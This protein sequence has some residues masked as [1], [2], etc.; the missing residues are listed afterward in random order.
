[1]KL[2]VWAIILVA[3]LSLSVGVRWEPAAQS[4]VTKLQAVQWLKPDAQKR[5]LEE[6]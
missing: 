5:L 1:M 3:A 4:T 6:Q 2:Q